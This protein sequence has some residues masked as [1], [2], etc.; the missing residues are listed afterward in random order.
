EG[1]ARPS[2][3]DEAA[4]LGIKADVSFGGEHL[5]D[6]TLRHLVDRH[7]GVAARGARDPGAG[8]GGSELGPDGVA[9][10]RRDVE[11]EPVR[12][13]HRVT[14]LRSTP[15]SESARKRSASWPRE[16]SLARGH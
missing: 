11:G 1:R 12:L 5:L 8:A 4:A 6:D 14:A 9:Y 13:G 15:T 3:R 10:A 2:V 7:R 16:N